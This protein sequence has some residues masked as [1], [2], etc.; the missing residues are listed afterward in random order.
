MQ[1]RNEIN[2][3]HHDC[4]AY[5]GMETARRSLGHHHIGFEKAGTLCLPVGIF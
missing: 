2:I 4:R 3:S 5:E 1:Y